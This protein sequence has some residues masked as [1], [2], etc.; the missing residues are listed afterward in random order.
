MHGG[1]R[2]TRIQAGLLTLTV[3]FFALSLIAPRYS[4]DQALQHIPLVLT[5]PVLVVGIRRRWFSNVAF[6]CICA[7]CWL[8]I[9]GARWLY[10]FVPYDA[11]FHA[12]FGSSPK[13]WFGWHRNNYDRFVHFCFGGLCVVVVAEAVARRGVSRSLSLLFAFCTVMTFSGSYEIVEW[14]ITLIVSPEHSEAYN[15][16]QGDFWDAQKDMAMAFLGA[17]A[18]LPLAYRRYPRIA[19]RH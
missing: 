6:A 3:V 19:G 5:F 17:L 12:I 14:L 7:F 13:E 10:S 9:I 11:W 15:G 18:A 4:L 2:S 8:H 16:Q 1:L